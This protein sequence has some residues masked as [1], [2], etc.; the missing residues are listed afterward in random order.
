M[1]KI[2]LSVAIFL[3]TS[4]ALA[5]NSFSVEAAVGRTEQKTLQEGYDVGV[6]IGGRRADSTSSSFKIGYEFT[7]SW[8]LEFGYDDYG[9][10]TL[11]TYNDS[12]SSSSSLRNITETAS[13]SATLITLKK[14]GAISD[15]LS[16]YARL[17]IARWELDLESAYPDTSQKLNFTWNESGIG[18][19]FGIGVYY[20]LTSNLQLSANYSFTQIRPDLF[21]KLKS[22][23][24]SRVYN[25]PANSSY[26]GDIKNYSIGVAYKF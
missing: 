20:Q 13:T 17:G 15:N 4:T 26:D 6:A 14:E 10:G 3:V 5:E 2:L 16:A 22:I 21:V 18:A 11:K 12:Y 23:S 19:Y 9:K 1:K 24:S 8:W 25:L 7:D